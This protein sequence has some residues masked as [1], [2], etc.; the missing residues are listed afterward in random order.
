MVYIVSLLSRFY[1]TSDLPKYPLGHSG[2]KEFVLH[3]YLADDTL[4]IREARDGSSSKTRP[5]SAA[6][7]GTKYLRRQ[8]L[9][10]STLGSSE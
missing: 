7:A 2:R 4:E 3:F 8:R 6:A 5:A 9:T 10:K 1:C